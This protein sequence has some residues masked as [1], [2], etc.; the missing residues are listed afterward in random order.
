MQASGLPVIPINPHLDVVGTVRCYPDL[1]SCPTRPDA[2]V[3]TTHPSVSLTIVKQCGEL[4]IK[5]VWFH[6]SVGDGSWSRE[7][8][9][10]CKK[11]GIDA[12]EGG[13]PM[14][15]LEPVDIA[16]ACMRWIFQW[17]GIAPR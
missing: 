1:A 15:F 12:I 2:V 11:W 17:T 6:R 13:C 3:I 4:G 7:A 5:K 8:A 9:D 14:M 10:E 16:H